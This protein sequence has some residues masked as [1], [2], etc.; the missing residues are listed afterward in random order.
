MQR[1]CLNPAAVSAHSEALSDRD[2]YA[3]RIVHCHIGCHCDSDSQPAPH[4]NH[5][6]SDHAYANTDERFIVD[7]NLAGWNCSQLTVNR[8]A[9]RTN[10]TSLCDEVTH[11]T[12]GTHGNDPVCQPEWIGRRMVSV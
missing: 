8:H 3:G 10:T 6:P 5:T 11:G 7:N 2:P 12:H 9:R 4:C 1:D